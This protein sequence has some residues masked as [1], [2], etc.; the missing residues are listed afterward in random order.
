MKRTTLINGQDVDI[1]DREGAG[2][3]KIFF[4]YASG[5]GT[6]TAMLDEA[7]G[8][9]GSGRDVLVAE[10]DQGNG[11]R[12][13]A[14]DLDQTLKRSPELV[15]L[16]NLARPNPAGHRNRT[17]YRDVEELLRSG[18]DVFVTMRVS[19]LLNEQDRV[20]ALQIAGPEDPVPDYL[21]YSAEQLEFVDIDPAELTLRCKSAG[22]PVPD[23]KT[24]G[25]LRVLA[26]RCVSEYA[27]SSNRVHAPTASSS[28]AFG[29]RVLAVVQVGE[30]PR[31]VLLGAARIAAL[32]HAPREAVCVR[33]PS[34]READ[35][36]AVDEEYR[37]LCEQVE[38]M[39]FELETLYGEDSAEVVRDYLRVQGVSDVVVARHRVSWPRRLLLP[40]Q[41]QFSDRIVDNVGDVQVHLV[42]T[43]SPTGARKVAERTL[44]RLMDFRLADLAAATAV[45]ALATIVARM[46]FSAGFGE[47]ST[48]LV[49]VAAIIA[50]ASSTRSYLPSVGA[51]VASS[52]LQVYFFIRPYRSFAIDHRASAMTFAF[53]AAVLVAMSVVVCRMARSSE[54]SRRRER[55]TQAL[56]DLNRSLV[57]AHG[58]VDVVDTSLEALVRL[59]DRSVAFY[60]RDPFARPSRIDRRAA[61]VR[62]VPGDYGKEEFEKVTSLAIAHWVFANG[63]AAGNG[64]STNGESDILFVP[65]SEE[66]EVV[67]VIG[68]SALR[69]LDLGDRSYLELVANQ[70]TLAF[71]RQ[72]LLVKHVGDVRLSHAVEVRSEFVGAVLQSASNSAHLVH[73]ISEALSRPTVD[74]QYREAL[75]RACADESARTHLMVSRVLGVLASAG[76]EPDCDLREQVG[77]AVDE[78]K[79]GLGGKVVELEPGDAS[80]RLF[81]D[82]ALV[83]LAVRL[84]LESSTNYVGKVGRVTVAIRSDD[85][86][87]TVVFSDDRP[88]NLGNAKPAALEVDGSMDTIANLAY[89]ERRAAAVWDVY[90]DAALMCSDP[91]DV[92]LALCRGMRIPEEVVREEGEGAPLNRMR[93]VRYDRTEYGLYMAALIVSAHGGTIRQRYR[94]GG[95]AVIGFTLPRER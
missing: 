77:L 60:V 30:S 54:R 82:S 76:V 17:R 36:N 26:L 47:P 55:N 73:D 86:V 32:S 15:V 64:T 50:I 7:R 3:L 62:T 89:D 35:A 40:V 11:V 69:G 38:A 48:Y 19:D 81:A 14:F 87:A 59:F 44:S 72:T 83:R 10:L 33:P 4:S 90:R 23:L 51:A 66:G 94:L 58:V 56:F 13:A 39:G 88:G 93:L 71:E 16:E 57:Y 92:L 9:M 24:L 6:T 12:G 28:P 1:L 75:L 53:C 78:V 79:S 74:P 84:I 22:K 8:H 52:L 34:R 65:L 42:C 20:A 67:G 2:A 41:L 29:D 25:E 91:Q 49:W 21:F 70:I 45:V 5:A 46:L 85:D 63:E 68:I 43:S 37:I 80:P 31:D 27:A 95:G 61:H 18:I